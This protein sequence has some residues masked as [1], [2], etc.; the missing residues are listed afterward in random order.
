MK[1]VCMLCLCDHS[2]HENKGH[3]YDQCGASTIVNECCAPIPYTKNGELHLLLHVTDGLA[4]V[5]IK[6]LQE[7][8]ISILILS[9]VNDGCKQICKC[10]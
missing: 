6:V 10:K 7:Y 4:N 2:F 1:H 3:S 5:S 9:T 8:F